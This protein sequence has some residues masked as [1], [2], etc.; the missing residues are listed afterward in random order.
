MLTSTN[1]CCSQLLACNLV[2]KN[3]GLS[4]GGHEADRGCIAVLTEAVLLGHLVRGSVR[5]SLGAQ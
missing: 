4:H 5:S 2:L 3:P 1:N